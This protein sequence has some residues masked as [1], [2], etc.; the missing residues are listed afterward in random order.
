MKEKINI[1][2]YANLITKALSKG[3]LLNTNGDI[4]VMVA[5]LALAR[6]S[7]RGRNTLWHD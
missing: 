2:D 4:G 6:L 1:T 7:G 3:I 5:I